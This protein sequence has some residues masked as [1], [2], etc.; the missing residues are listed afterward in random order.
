MIATEARAR[1]LS[2]N[3]L[4][5]IRETLEDALFEICM[6]SAGNDSADE[7][8]ITTDNIRRCLELIRDE[9]DTLY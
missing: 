7:T 5:F 8:E 3:D 6:F 9:Q 4:Q 2:E 1:M